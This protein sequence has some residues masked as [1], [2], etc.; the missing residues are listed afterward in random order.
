ML[1]NNF[2]IKRFIMFKFVTK[3]SIHFI[4]NSNTVT[5]KYGLISSLIEEF[6]DEEINLDISSHD[7]ELIEGFTV[8]RE[9]PQQKQDWIDLI[10]TAEYLD[11][12]LSLSWLLEKYAL[13]YLGEEKI[14]YTE[15]IDLRIILDNL[16]KR[17][18]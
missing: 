7:W 12:N 13:E 15:P 5:R 11:L 14:S 3:D 6:P 18:D 17:K 16:Q 10:R 1:N 4:K 9:I 8:T 2:V